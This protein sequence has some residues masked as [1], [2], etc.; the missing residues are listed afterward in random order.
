MA[1]LVC[2]HAHPDDEAIA[3]GGVMAMAKADGHKVILLVATRGE[4]GEPVDGVLKPGEAL[5]DRRELETHTSAAILGADGV[6]FLDYRDSGMIG[7]SSN[8]DP[9][10]FWQADVEHAA[11]QVAALLT[12]VEADVLTVY[13]SHGGY[14]HPDHIQVN[15]VGTRAA[16]IAGTDRVFW[17]TMNR[18]QI[19]E[20]QE[21]LPDRDDDDIDI[22]TE[23]FGMEE[24]DLTHAV[25]VSDFIEQK[26]QSMAAHESQIDDESFFMSMPPEV[27]AMAFGTEWFVAPGEPR[28]A[29]QRKDGTFATSLF[30]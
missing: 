23:E 30:G 18:T 27:F 2:F 20:M 12:E 17:A 25:D 10:C 13:D 4:M 22:E 1:T 24:D 11:Q 8:D 9:A 7:E 16:E 3:T 21:Q 5:G 28:T 6:A 29:Q 26:R 14:G 19:L 15:R